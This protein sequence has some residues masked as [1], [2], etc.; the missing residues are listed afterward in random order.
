MQTRMLELSSGDRPSDLDNNNQMI[1]PSYAGGNNSERKQGS[2]G[3][4][5][6]LMEV[7]RTHSAY[8]GAQQPPHYVGISEFYQGDPMAALRSTFPA[9]LLSPWAINY[10]YDNTKEV[11]IELLG[12][13]N[14]RLRHDERWVKAQYREERILSEKIAFIRHFFPKFAVDPTKLVADME[15]TFS[16]ALSVPIDDEKH[17]ASLAIGFRTWSLDKDFANPMPLG[18]RFKWMTPLRSNQSGG[19]AFKEASI[20]SAENLYYPPR[21]HLELSGDELRRMQNVCSS[22][23]L[24]KVAVSFM[25][26]QD[27]RSGKQL[28]ADQT[29]TYIYFVGRSAQNPRREIL[30]VKKA[31]TGQVRPADWVSISVLSA[32]LLRML[33]VDAPDSWLH[34]NYPFT[35]LTSV[36]EGFYIPPYVKHVRSL[37]PKSVVTPN[38]PSYTNPAERGVTGVL[39][40]VGMGGLASDIIGTVR[41]VLHNKNINIEEAMIDEPYFTQLLAAVLDAQVFPNAKKAIFDRMMDADTAETTAACIAIAQ[42]LK[43]G[44]RIPLLPGVNTLEVARSLDAYL[45]EHDDLTLPT[46]II[47]MGLLTG[48]NIA[49]SENPNVQEVT[50]ETLEKL[51]GLIDAIYG[52]L[53]EH[54]Y[55]RSTG[56]I[57]VNRKTQ[58]TVLDELHKGVRQQAEA[59]AQ[60]RERQQAEERRQGMEVLANT[61]THENLGVNPSVD[62]PAYFAS[63]FKHCGFDVE[64]TINYIKVQKAERDR[65]KA[66]VAAKPDK[67]TGAKRI[68]S[69]TTKMVGA[70]TRSG[71]KP[72][73]NLERIIKRRI[74]PGVGA[75]LLIFALVRGCANNND[76]STIEVPGGN[77]NQVTLTQ[78]A[79]A[80]EGAVLPTDE[81]ESP[82]PEV[83][84]NETQSTDDKG[85]NYDANWAFAKGLTESSIPEAQSENGG[86]LCGPAEVKLEANAVYAVLGRTADGKTKVFG[87]L[88]TGPAG[89]PAIQMARCE[90]GYQKEGFLADAASDSNLTSDEIAKL[91]EGAYAYVVLARQNANGS[92]YLVADPKKLINGDLSSLLGEKDAQG[93]RLGNVIL[94][95][96]R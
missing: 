24:N 37:R 44:S 15:R 11:P 54:L 82:T 79:R 78:T 21:M 86:K 59:E 6:Y 17:L 10:L 57:V 52:K 34:V 23:F 71:G 29:N 68:N 84:E 22:V 80:G 92:T 2:T 47:L 40:R 94:S 18:A 61:F 72:P 39:N 83:E 9:A 32:G 88:S 8:A 4:M 90:L 87:K 7:S 65:A 13:V 63:C 14:E 27:L 12:V 62:L 56:Q 81:E 96:I 66:E 33:P 26:P 5:H 31:E 69:G 45:F 55:G 25:Q 50:D 49:A 75:A 70:A 60:A 42:S 30:M 1:M 16:G 46:I 41:E 48:S 20:I 64:T 43:D 38:D 89:N 93:S 58:D 53:K 91:Q 28:T 3:A 77:D 51:T 74:A 35:A 36:E 95:Q 76:S 73:M 67:A 85:E 19:N